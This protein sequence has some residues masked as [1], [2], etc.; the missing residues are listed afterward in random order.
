MDQCQ[1]ILCEQE[2]PIINRIKFKK[3]SLNNHPDKVKN[4]DQDIVNKKFQSVAECVDQYL[5]ENTSKINCIKSPIKNVTPKKQIPKK[6]KKKSS[7]IR[8]IENWTNIDRYHRFDKPTFNP[9]KVIEDIKNFSPKMNKMINIINQID[10]RDNIKYGKT[11]KHFIF[12]D[13]KEGGYGSKIIASSLIA[14]GFKSCFKKPYNFC[15]LN[16]LIF[17]YY[18]TLGKK[19]R[20]INSYFKLSCFIYCECS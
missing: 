1:K 15:L 9:K 18:S 16:D 14:H 19:F 6:N 3:W 7:C 13:V 2:P 10:T 20:Y 11:F 17:I 12:S 5:P 8:K 4:E